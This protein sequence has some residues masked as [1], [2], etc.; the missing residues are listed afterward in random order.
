LVLQRFQ[1]RAEARGFVKSGNYDGNGGHTRSLEIVGHRLC[2]PKHN[3][4]REK[5]SCKI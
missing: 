1:Q 5:S 4:W 2:I 3:S